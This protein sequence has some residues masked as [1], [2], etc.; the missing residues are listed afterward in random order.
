MHSFA[1]VRI[2]LRRHLSAEPNHVTQPLG[3]AIRQFGRPVPDPL[4]PGVFSRDVLIVTVA[5][6]SHR[7]H[8]NA[9]H[10]LVVFSKMTGNHGGRGAGLCKVGCP[11]L[12]EWGPLRP[13]NTLIVALEFDR[14]LKCGTHRPQVT[15]ERFHDCVALIH[16][17]D[18]PV[19]S[20][21]TVRRCPVGGCNKL[22]H[23]KCCGNYRL[24]PRICRRN[25]RRILHNLVRHITPATLGN[26]L[27]L[28][29]LAFKW[30]HF[31]GD[32]RDHRS[33]IARQDIEQHSHHRTLVNIKRQLNKGLDPNDISQ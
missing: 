14:I 28:N 29:F 27:K 11:S 3:L 12:G 13:G 17:I 10:G 6:L 9:G 8:T 15:I 33:W 20:I 25:S 19:I 21:Y 2:R 32:D 1:G 5:P 23:P 31:N 30:L 22:A 26:R 16:P 24:S 7:Q 4:R 18:T